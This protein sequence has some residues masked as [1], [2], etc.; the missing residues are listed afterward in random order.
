MSNFR[1]A[2]VMLFALLAVVGASASQADAQERHSMT[3]NLTGAASVW[4]Q[5]DQ[6]GFDSLVLGA[7]NFVNATFVDRWVVGWGDLSVA[8]NL[9]RARAVWVQDQRGA[10]DSYVIGAPDFVNAGFATR[11]IADRSSQ[12]PPTTPTGLTATKVDIQFGP[13]DIWVS[14]TPVSGA[15]QYD[16]IHSSGGEFAFRGS[17]ASAG[18]LDQDP[19]LLSADTYAVRACN[20]MGCSEYS[21][22][23]TEGADSFVGSLLSTLT[24]LGYGPV[25]ICTMLVTLGVEVLITQAVPVLSPIAS[26]IAPWVAAAIAERLGCG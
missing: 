22:G 9:D 19:S 18:Y 6:G 15:T 17:V 1:N 4:V 13:D 16:V 23:V 20:A 14:W 25:E 8:L 26:F 7:P 12:G 3:L 10:F 11:W 21:L 2:A 5:D 24:A